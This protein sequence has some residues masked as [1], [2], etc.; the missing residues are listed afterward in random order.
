MISLCN[1]I[2]MQIKVVF[3][4]LVSHLDSLWSEGTRELGNGLFQ[5]F[6]IIACRRKFL[7]IL[8]VKESNNQ[9]FQEE[10][11]EYLEW[12]AAVNISYAFFSKRKFETSIPC[13]QI[14]IWLSLIS[15]PHAQLTWPA[16]VASPKEILVLDKRAKSKTNFISTAMTLDG[17]SWNEDTS[18]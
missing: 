11:M 14:K 3:I 2:F 7:R 6:R 9:C 12:K 13:D 1:F 10:V 17:R 15:N 8:Y 16:P 18:Y 5:Y 4:S